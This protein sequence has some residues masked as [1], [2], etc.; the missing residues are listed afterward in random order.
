VLILCFFSVEVVEEEE[1]K[2]ASPVKRGKRK[3]AEAPV[4]SPPKRA[5]RAKR[6]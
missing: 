3:A 2:P 1:A 4:A 5:T 6:K